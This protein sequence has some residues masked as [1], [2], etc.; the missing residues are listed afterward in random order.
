MARRFSGHLQVGY[1]DCF[2]GAGGDMMLGALLNAG[3]PEEELRRTLA[4]L[5][6]ENWDLRIRSCR[7]SGIRATAVQVRVT[8]EQP[9]R[10]FGDIREML[11]ALPLEREIS[12]GALAVFEQLA[13]AEARVH[14]CAIHEVHFHETG[15]VDALVDVLGVVAGLRYLGV[16]S[17]V[18]SPLPMPGGWVECEHGMLPLPA[19]AV[20]ELLK[21][22]PVYGVRLEQELVTPTAAA[23]I[24][25]IGSTFGPL[26]PL[27]IE[28][29]GYGAG[30]RERPDGRPNLLRLII[31]CAVRVD[32]AQEVEVVETSLDDFNPEIWPH[33]CQRIMAAGALDVNLVPCQMKKGRPGFL[34]RVVVAPAESIGVKEAILRETSAI[35]LR[36]RR[37][38][39]M[40]LPRDFDT[41]ETPWGEVRVKVVETADGL[42]RTPEY[43]DCRRVA[44]R[45]G[46]PIR[47]VYSAIRWQD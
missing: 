29:V 32:E 11:H 13:R 10:R 4:A 38:W 21:G 42:V 36:F 35:G 9:C 17:V 45:E 27:R 19:P 26:P 7:K 22:V 3:L 46:I 20:C 44:E 40:T 5:P 47:A 31:G 1:L 23:I 12:Q 41:V 34:L 18:C 25:G 8:G 2:S 33:V 37:E 28:T 14:G 6:L 24:R 43:E 39:R 30:S 16:E 15:G